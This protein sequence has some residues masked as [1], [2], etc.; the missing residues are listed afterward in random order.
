MTSRGVY[1]FNFKMARD[2][3]KY[4]INSCIMYGLVDLVSK[5]LMQMYLIYTIYIFKILEMYIL[6]Y[7]HYLIYAMNFVEKCD[8][9]T[10]SQLH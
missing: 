3:E 10:H 1:V 8:N 4:R 5:C 2:T 6:K 7:N 9:I